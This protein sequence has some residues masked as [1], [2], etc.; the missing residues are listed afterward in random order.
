VS[1]ETSLEDFRNG[2]TLSTLGASA[3]LDVHSAIAVSSHL[4]A[5]S[6]FNSSSETPGSKINLKYVS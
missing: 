2:S 1:Y 6:L 5:A 4:N 3:S